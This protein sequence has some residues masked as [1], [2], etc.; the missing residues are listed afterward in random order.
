M[1]ELVSVG[2]IKEAVKTILKASPN[3]FFCIF[4]LII[5]PLS[6]LQFMLETNNLALAICITDVY[7]KSSP[8]YLYANSLLPYE[9]IVG[10]YS[11]AYFLLKLKSIQYYCVSLVLFFAFYLLAISATTFTLAT[12]YLPKPLSHISILSSVPGIFKRLAITFCHAVPFVFLN[13]IAYLVVHTLC[14][15]ILTLIRTTPEI[16]QVL[17]SVIGF[18]FFLIYLSIFLVVHGR[19]IARWN[20]AN[21]VS[22]VEPDTYG[23]GAI[24]KSKKLLWDKKII[25]AILYLAVAI[26]IVCFGN[27]VMSH[28]MNI[29]ARVFVCFSSVMALAVV[30]FLGLIAQI[31]MYYQNQVIVL[32]ESGLQVNG[33]VLAKMRRFVRND[34]RVEGNQLE[35]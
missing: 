35:V 14:C 23:S 31:L 12:F 3:K 17:V 11:S 34:N 18:I 26:D 21:V 33:I 27:W 16:D 1:K 8:E 32:N 29:K 30:N 10:T 20:F 28:D 5:L 22:V 19:F 24:K 15:M 4:L 2:C 7:D 6:F 25:L 13:Y 9:Q